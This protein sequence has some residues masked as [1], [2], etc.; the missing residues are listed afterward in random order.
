MHPG[1]CFLI[2]IVALVS[3]PW[4]MWCLHSHINRTKWD[5]LAL[6]GTVIILEAQAHYNLG[7]I[8]PIMRVFVFKSCF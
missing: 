6:A 5:T 1:N 3:A 8:C 4:I 2:I 7:I